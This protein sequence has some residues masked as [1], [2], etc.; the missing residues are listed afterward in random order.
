MF[1]KEKVYHLLTFLFSVLNLSDAD[2]QIRVATTS[3]TNLIYGNS[4]FMEVLEPED[5][6]FLYK[7][8]PA[9]N[10]GAVF[11]KKYTGMQL[12]LGNPYS[13][14][15]SLQNHEIVRDRIVMLQ[16]GEC[17]FVTKTFH[18]Q[19][20]GA[21]ATIITDNDKNNDDST[22][23]MI[24]DETDREINIPALFLL[25]KDGYMIKSS[26]ERYGLMGATINIPVNLTGVPIN[27]VNKP[28][29]TL[30]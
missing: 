23:D 28:P 9:K 7:I 18:A 5:I 13:G 20:A 25:G 6:N 21:V 22:I 8:R 16:R 12:I 24:K 19:I 14:C 26:I 11:E 2:D 27:N 3:D 4:L 30:W 29:W 10:F 15:S 1:C 17:S